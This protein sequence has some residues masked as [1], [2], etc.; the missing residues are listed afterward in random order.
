VSTGFPIV[1]SK[2]RY[3]AQ[4]L[5]GK[6]VTRPANVVPSRIRRTSE[7][8]VP[9]GVAKSRA[10]NAAVG[11]LIVGAVARNWQPSI[12][13]ARATHA[14]CSERGGRSRPCLA[15]MSRRPPRCGPDKSCS[16]SACII[17]VDPYR[18][19]PRVPLGCRCRVRREK[20]FSPRSPRGCSAQPRS[21]CDRHA[22]A[23]GRL[24][25]ADHQAARRFPEI[26]PIWVLE[27]GKPAE[28]ESH[29][30]GPGPFQKARSR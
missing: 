4:S 3:A 24:P 10:P 18:P 28:T 17:P 5:N 8:T 30:C 7:P 26:G 6:N 22:G 21:G 9:E 20:S 23:Q 27:S 2:R 15:L 25:P 19:A 16:L 12:N 13:S 14:T 11:A 29:A 1:R